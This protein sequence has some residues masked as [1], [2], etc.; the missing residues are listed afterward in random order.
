MQKIL[1]VPPITI[2]E[3]VDFLH[4]KAPQAKVRVVES[5]SFY[6]M[7]VGNC[8]TDGYRQK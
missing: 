6:F 5:S 7:H 8:F 4:A 1:Q 3:F 2:H